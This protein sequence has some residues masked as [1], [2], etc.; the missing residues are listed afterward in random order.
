MGDKCKII[1]KG[2]SKN[3]IYLM[4]WRHKNIRLLRKR[5]LEN[6]VIFSWLRTSRP[7]SGQSTRP[8]WTGGDF[9]PSQ[10]ASLD[11]ILF[12]RYRSP[13][14]TGQW[15]TELR[16]TVTLKKPSTKIMI[17]SSHGLAC[18]SSHFVWSFLDTTDVVHI[19]RAAFA[20][21]LSLKALYFVKKDW[22]FHWL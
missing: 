15:G 10:K 17:L 2:P 12:T 16:E 21:L 8:W 6:F 1:L 7:T 13:T 11:A 22:C 4:P 14:V 20:R 9:G 18:T 5:A 3:H 19:V